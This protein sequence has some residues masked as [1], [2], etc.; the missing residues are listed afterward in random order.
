MLAR[1]ETLEQ[2]VER[3]QD[4]SSQTRS[5][6][7]VSR[8]VRYPLCHFLMHPISNIGDTAKL[9]LFDRMMNHFT[10]QVK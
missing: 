7:K 3:S 2:L 9:M 4:L 1:G 10:T 8:Q 5:F 6:Y